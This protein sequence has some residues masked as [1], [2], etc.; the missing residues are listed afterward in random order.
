MNIVTEF[1]I[2]SPSLPLVSIPK[3]LEAN[4]IECIHALCLQSDIRTFTIRIDP[5]DNVSTED[6]SALDEIMETT[7]L[8]ETNDGIVY[9]LMVELDEPTSNAFNSEHIDATQLASTTITDHQWHE[10]KLF[11]DYDSFTDFRENCESHGITFELLS[12]V[13]NPSASNGVGGDSLTDRQ[14]EALS[15][16]LSR[17]YYESPRKATAQDLAEEFDIS[18]PAMSSLLRRGERQLLSSSLEPYGKLNSLSI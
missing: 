12:I 7:L 8:G 2:S 16:A 9:Q 11:S 10:K 6:L 13:S 14:R 18:Q 3:T 17:G 1:I 4:K 5:D 15:L